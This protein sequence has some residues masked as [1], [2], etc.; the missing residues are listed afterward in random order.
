MLGAKGIRSSERTADHVEAFGNWR[1]I[2]VAE[3]DLPRKSS[4]LAETDLPA[5]RGHG[6]G[7]TLDA[8][9]MEAG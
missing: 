6:G 4:S 5:S 1:E 2:L 3:A 9:R 8:A 7:R